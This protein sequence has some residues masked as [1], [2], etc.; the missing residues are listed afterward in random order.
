MGDDDVDE[1]TNPFST[2]SEIAA[3]QER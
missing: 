1:H 3:P 2:S